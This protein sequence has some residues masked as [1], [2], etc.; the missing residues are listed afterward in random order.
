MSAVVACAPIA[1]E[2][3]SATDANGDG[4]VAPVV[5][6]DG[7]AGALFADAA[8]VTPGGSAPG[9]RTA[10]GDV[11]ACN[12][13]DGSACLADAAAP[14]DASSTDG[15][16]VYDASGTTPATDA[17][18][19]IT[20]DASDS[21]ASAS[22]AARLACV[23]FASGRGAA[24]VAGGNARAGA[25]CTGPAECAPGTACVL[26]RCM[27][28]CCARA[29]ACP[30]GTACTLAATTGA[31]A[32]W[33]PVCAPLRPCSFDADFGLGAADAGVLCPDG[34]QCGFASDEGVRA[35]VPLGRAREGEP[36][37][38]EPCAGG[39]ACVGSRSLE[40]C[41]RLCTTDGARGCPAGMRCRAHPA[42]LGTSNVGY[43]AP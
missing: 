18:A 17:G 15:G 28:T 7:G 2:D 10:C 35:C 9:Y 40:R 5:G 1:L 37:A 4:G 33:L 20:V 26:A 24:C 36:C 34:A 42:L 30:A 19:A 6:G 31:S 39:L 38:A 29:T 32:P 23:P 11:F 25:S 13:D 3:A 21:D 16:S 43:C 27:P 41:A 12:P 8:S 14:A 22:S